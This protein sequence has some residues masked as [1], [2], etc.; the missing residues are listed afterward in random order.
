MAVFC[1]EVFS[2]NTEFLDNLN[3][4]RRAFI[5][6]SV[7]YS[8]YGTHE[9]SESR[10]PRGMCRLHCSSYGRNRPARGWGLTLLLGKTARTSPH[11]RH[12]SR[13]VPFTKWT[14]SGAVMAKLKAWPVTSSPSVTSNTLFMSMLAWGTVSGWNNTNKWNESLKFVTMVRSLY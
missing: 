13:Q 1:E 6:P 4:N 14:R 11:H 12:S 7:Q 9:P 10:P 3:K 8:V 5:N 2:N